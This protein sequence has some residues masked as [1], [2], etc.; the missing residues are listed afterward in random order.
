MKRKTTSRFFQK[1]CICHCTPEDISNV[2]IEAAEHALS[3]LG[4]GH[5]ETT[6]EHIIL[7]YLYDKR[8]PTRRQVK[9][10]VKISQDVVQAGILDLEI[11]RSVLIEL[12]AGLSD[13][14][15]E[16][17]TQ[18]RRYMRCAEKNYSNRPLIGMLVLF[19]KCGEIKIWKTVID[20]TCDRPLEK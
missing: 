9:F 12:K 15:L 16:H 8:I 4:T 2:V 17:R 7:N 13:I 14:T 19:S 1:S 20:D 6:Y 3:E 18:L 10:F 11:D 5:S